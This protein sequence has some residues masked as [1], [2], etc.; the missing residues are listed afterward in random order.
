[1]CTVLLETWIVA[2]AQ[3]RVELCEFLCSDYQRPHLHT[4]IFVFNRFFGRV[5]LRTFSEFGSVLAGLENHRRIFWNQRIETELWM[6]M[7]L[8]KLS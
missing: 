7:L 2:C 1:M 6:P 8:L 5:V 3:A 4:G